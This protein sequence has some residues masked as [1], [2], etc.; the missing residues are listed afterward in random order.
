MAFHSL[1][2]EYPFRTHNLKQSLEFLEGCYKQKA[3]EKITPNVE[4]YATQLGVEYN[5]FLISDLKYRWG[6]CTLKGNLNFN[7][8]LRSG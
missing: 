7:W 6:S 2:T 1:P 8:R 3:R 4:R 5:K